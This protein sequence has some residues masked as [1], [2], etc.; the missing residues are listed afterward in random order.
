MAGGNRKCEDVTDALIVGDRDGVL[1][2]EDVCMTAAVW[3]LVPN[4]DVACV[5]V[6][7]TLIVDTCDAVLVAL[8]VLELFRE[9]LHVPVRDADSVNE[10]A[11]LTLAD[12]SDED[13]AGDAVRELE[14]VAGVEAVKVTV[15][16][17]A[18]EVPD[19]PVV[20]VDSDGGGLRSG[21]SSAGPV[22]VEICERV[23]D[24]VEVP[25]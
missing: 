6:E 18:D 16:E 19:V 11:G 20:G 17:H 22:S 15:H 5:D 8:A 2:R 10:E 23:S 7:V 13:I 14:C 4:R 25:S 9:A 3:L 1:D 24:G 21:S 12:C